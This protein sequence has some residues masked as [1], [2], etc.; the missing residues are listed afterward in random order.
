MF[1]GNDNP[2]KKITHG[3]I[4]EQFTM[5]ESKEKNLRKTGALENEMASLYGHDVIHG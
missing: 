5:V 1:I 3:M 4:E 2:N